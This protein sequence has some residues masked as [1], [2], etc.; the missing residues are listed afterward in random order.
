[1]EIVEVMG[2]FFGGIMLF[3]VLLTASQFTL[4]AS[5]YTSAKARNVSNPLLYAAATM[6]GGVVTAI[7]Y[8]CIKK[9]VTRTDN[10]KS[11]SSV[12]WLVLSCVLVFAAFV[13]YIVAFVGYIT[14]M[15][16]IG[17]AY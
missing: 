10:V 6:V 3:A 1:M 11:S 14:G 5:V 7:M 12:F 4:A 9:K 16:S 8:A 15:V 2:G 17:A 13:A